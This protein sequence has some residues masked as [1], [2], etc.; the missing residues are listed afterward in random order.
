L[1][2]A[3]V[4][5]VVGGRSLNIQLAISHREL[6]QVLLNLFMNACDAMPKGGT[7]TL[8]CDSADPRAVITVADTG[9]GI[10]PAQLGEIFTPFYTTK[11]SRGTG[12][13]LSVAASILRAHKGDIAVESEPGRGTTF[14]L[15]VPVS[16]ST[17]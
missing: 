16:G 1:S 5:L 7:I 6:V 8:T 15:R 4:R 17:A 12:L 2:H 3:G 9:S 11:G 14:T 10:P 13:G